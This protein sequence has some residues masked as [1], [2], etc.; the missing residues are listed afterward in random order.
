MSDDDTSDEKSDLA[1]DAGADAD[2]EVAELVP[3][4]AGGGGPSGRTIAG[5][6]VGVV[7]VVG[8][9]VGLVASRNQKN[10]AKQGGATS[11]AT[12]DGVTISRAALDA[13]LASWIA[14]KDYVAAAK[15]QGQVMTQANG[16]VAPEFQRIILAQQIEDVVFTREF[17]RRHLKVT[18]SDLAQFKQQVAANPALAKFPKTFIDSIIAR[19]ARLTV[20]RA[21][22]TT[23]P[24]AADIQKA[25][26]AQYGC[27]TGK[28]V[29]HILV[30]TL[31]EANTLESQLASGAKFATLAKSKSTDT[32]SAASG[33][34]LGCLRKGTF[35]K[36]FEDAALAA[37]DGTPT[38]P[39]KSQFGYHI[40]LVHAHT[41]SG[42]SLASV[43]AQIVQTL[44]QNSTTFNDY[45]KKALSSAKV[46]V[47]PTLGYWGNGAQGYEVQ[48][49]RAGGSTG[50]TSGA[51]GSSGSSSTPLSVAN[52]RPKNKP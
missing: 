4:P 10:D 31:A 11:A 23:E 9:V 52:E 19:A 16:R 2:V 45:A 26:D 29:A 25:Y 5:A 24:T 20:L 41:A 14:N 27:P 37:V 46:T 36:P 50:S 6:V 44:Q 1:A 18:A 12:V 8:I 48:A 38:A 43:R 17:N 30:K 13:E 34:E 35:V 40:I 42:P 28:D 33:G 22:L 7:L 21:A 51:K 32:G 3:A 49:P 15:G 47:D 39:V